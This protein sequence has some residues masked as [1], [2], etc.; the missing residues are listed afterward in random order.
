[1]TNKVNEKVIK[2]EEEVYDI[3]LRLNTGESNAAQFSTDK[4]NG[5]LKAIILSNIKPIDVLI[6]SA[7]GYQIYA[8]QQHIG[9]HYFPLVIT[10]LNQNAHAKGYSGDIFHLNENLFITV[11]GPKN[12]DID[13]ILR[14]A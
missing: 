2:G 9:T 3:R 5:K 1:M 14:F 12:Q 10:A 11:I 8:E 6:E 7:L 13:I 4:I